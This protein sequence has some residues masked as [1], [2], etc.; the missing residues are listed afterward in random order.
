MCESLVDE[1]LSTL[2]TIKAFVGGG[3]L[4]GYTEFF[5]PKVPEYMELANKEFMRWALNWTLEER[6]VSKVEIDESEIQSGD[7]F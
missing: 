6:P 7:N 2:T 4:H 1:V 3:G 5:Q